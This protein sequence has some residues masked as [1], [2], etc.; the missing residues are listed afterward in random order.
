MG[1]PNKPSALVLEEDFAKQLRLARYLAASSLPPSWPLE[2]ALKARSRNRG[3]VLEKRRP[4]ARQN[5]RGKRLGRRNWRKRGDGREGRLIKFNQSV[6]SGEKSSDLGG[7]LMTESERP[8]SCTWCFL[9]R[10][11]GCCGPVVLVGFNDLKPNPFRLEM[12]A[13]CRPG[14]HWSASPPP[15][16]PYGSKAGSMCWLFEVANPDKP[17]SGNC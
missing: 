7:S 4:K 15:L 6:P 16:L 3:G 9:I 2:P 12:G 10:L 8:S 11:A 14:F 13:T 1:F 17:D 5:R